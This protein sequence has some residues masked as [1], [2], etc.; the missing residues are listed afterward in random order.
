MSQTQAP[1]VKL[2]DVT[3]PKAAHSGSNS[4][5]A[6]VQTKTPTATNRDKYENKPMPP[7]P[8][9][10][11]SPVAKPLTARK[12]R[13]YIQ[14]ATPLIT[15]DQMM[16]NRAVTDP[17]MPKPLF[18]SKTGTVH[19]L[20]KKY[21]QTRNKG[22]SIK[23]QEEVADHPPSPPLIISQ[24]A[25]QILGVFPS[26][27]NIRETTPA[28]APPSTYTPDPFR[29]SA[30]S[31]KGRNTSPNRQVQSTPVLTRRYLQENS[32]PTV[33]VTPTSQGPEEVPA[34]SVTENK[35]PQSSD[36]TTVGNGSLNP[37]RLGTYGRTGEVGYV[38]QHELYRALSF[39]GVIED[40]GAPERRQDQMEPESIM[41]DWNENALRPQYSG[42]ILHPMVYSPNHYG[43]VWENDPH[44]VSEALCIVSES[45]AVTPCPGLHA[46]TLQP[47]SSTAASS[48]IFGG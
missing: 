26:K 48:S 47:F 43:G 19:Q 37:T 28:S 25:S 31:T 44:V 17:V 27:D 45:S 10:S 42:E 3:P 13:L 8:E 20:R 5:A 38:G 30:E 36:A 15:P 39:S 35:H 32:L 2:P 18:M 6:Q 7:T 29:T 24:K 1:R 9:A 22:K 40:A 41:T 21:S 11:P 34:V 4:W 46:T 33:S 14:P 12:N 23:D 16:K